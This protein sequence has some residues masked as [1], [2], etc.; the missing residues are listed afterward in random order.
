MNAVGHHFGRRPYDNAAGNLQWLAL[1]TAGEGCTT[2]TTPRPR[3]PA[4]S[5]RW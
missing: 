4:S 3:R 5:H 1:I 2:T